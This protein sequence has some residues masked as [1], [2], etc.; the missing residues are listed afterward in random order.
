MS[1]SQTRSWSLADDA[2]L[3]ELYRDDRTLREIAD[4]LGVAIH[5]VWSRISALRARGVELPPRRPR[6]TAERRELLARCR[7]EGYSLRE[8]EMEFERTRGT[9]TSQLRTLRRLGY[10]VSKPPT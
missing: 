8:P 9:I 4:E 2:R 6:W 3:E 7:R 5:Q 1:S 10:D